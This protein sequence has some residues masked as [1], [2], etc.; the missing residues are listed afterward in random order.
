M[1]SG[2]ETG[3]S[4]HWRRSRGGQDGW[5]APQDQRVRP[6]NEPLRLT[7]LDDAMDLDL[8]CHRRGRRRGQLAARLQWADGKLLP[9]TGEG[10]N[11]ATPLPE[12]GTW[13]INC[14]CG[15]QHAVDLALLAKEARHAGPRGRK[16]KSLDLQRVVLPPPA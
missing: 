7:S 6:S 8:R 3:S 10:L 1:V 16:P 2:N 11:H 9:M 12:V 14:V 5:D 15:G 4:T 13:L